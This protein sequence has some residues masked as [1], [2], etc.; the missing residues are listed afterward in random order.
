VTEVSGGC[1]PL[2]I[3]HA[4]PAGPPLPEVAVG[5]VVVDVTDRLQVGVA[6]RCAEEFEAAFLHVLADRV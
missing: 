1:I 2:R 3:G 4:S 5:E 6:D